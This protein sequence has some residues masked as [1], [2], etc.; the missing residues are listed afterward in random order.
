MSAG[1]VLAA[2]GAAAAATA[3]HLVRWA[4]QRPHPP[5]PRRRPLPGGRAYRIPGDDVVL[6]AERDPDMQPCDRRAEAWALDQLLTTAE[7][8]RMEQLLRQGVQR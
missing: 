7:R 6:A 4:S 2:I 3:W 5:T 1:I 8:R